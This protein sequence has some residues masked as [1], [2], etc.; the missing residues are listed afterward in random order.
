[1]VP[2]K[3]EA[4]QDDVA[5]RP[6]LVMFDQTLY[7]LFALDGGNPDEVAMMLALVPPISPVSSALPESLKYTFQSP[8]RP[9]LDKDL[10]ARICLANA[11]QNHAVSMGPMR[12]ILFD[13]DPPEYDVVNGLVESPPGPRTDATR[14]FDAIVPSQRPKLSF[15]SDAA[16]WQPEPGVK[17]SPYPPQDF[18]DKHSTILSQESHYNL[19]SKRGLALS[20]LPTPKTEVIDGILEPADVLDDAK[21]ETE[22][23]RI[24]QE[25]RSKPFPFV[26]KFPLSAAGQGVFVVRDA[27][28]LAA[29][30]RNGR[31]AA[32]IPKMIRA[33]RPDNAHLS[34][35]SLCIQDMVEGETRNLS[36]FVTKA[37][38][39]VFLS[40][41]EQFL[42]ENGIWR[43]SILDYARQAEF[44]PQYRPTLEKI[45]AYVHGH[46]FYGP[47]GG[48]I[49]TDAQGN[50]YIVD[51]NTRVTGDVFMGP[52]RGHFYER[53]GMRYSYI[54]SPVVTLGNR[55]RFEKIFWPE[56]IEGRMIIIGWVRGRGGLFG[57]H[58]YSVGSV[59]IGAKDKTELFELV[60]RVNAV[61]YTTAPN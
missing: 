13:V 55:D 12:L 23:Q 39:A 37:G 3:S 1:M 42:D 44:E 7:D 51:L 38:R 52:L 40:C 22:T 48:D 53:R 10:F 15:V 30:E 32:E 56:L 61:G 36:I 4:P 58:E 45:A 5:E 57:K 6:P 20:G 49:M 35:V 54:I 19:L 8:A 34:P 2:G 28:G 26:I 29:A 33:L 11:A 24:L 21:V 17:I 41:C 43:A 18:L 46:G 25:I 47:M 14:V 16:T 31:F 9:N 59:M 60:E 50:Q 27:A